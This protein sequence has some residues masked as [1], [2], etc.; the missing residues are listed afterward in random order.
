MKLDDAKDEG[1]YLKQ[2]GE[3]PQAFRLR[4]SNAMNEQTSTL[5]QN[6]EAKQFPMHPLAKPGPQGWDKFAAGQR[7]EVANELA[8]LNNGTTASKA[9]QSGVFERLGA[10]NPGGVRPAKTTAAIA[11]SKYVTAGTVEGKTA[12]KG[13]GGK[14]VITRS[15]PQATSRLG[16]LENR[17]NNPSQSPAFRDNQGHFK[18]PR[19]GMAARQTHIMQTAKK[20]D[21]LMRDLLNPANNNTLPN[22]FDKDDRLNHGYLYNG[23]SLDAGGEMYNTATGAKQYAVGAQKFG[24]NEKIVPT[25][26]GAHVAPSKANETQ[27]RTNLWSEADVDPIRATHMAGNGYVTL[28]NRGTDRL[29]HTAANTTVETPNGQGT[30]SPKTVDSRFHITNDHYKSAVPISPVEQNYKTGKNYPLPYADKTLAAGGVGP[31]RTSLAVQES[32]AKKRAEQARGDDGALR[33][34]ASV[35]YREEA[36]EDAKQASRR[37][38]VEESK[39]VQME[40]MIE[41]QLPNDARQA[42]MTASYNRNAEER[43]R[44]KVAGMV[45]DFLPEQALIDAK[46]AS[47]RREA[48]EEERTQ[49]DLKKF[50]PSDSI[51]AMYGMG[52]AGANKFA[53]S[54]L[55]AQH[56]S[57]QQFL[58]PGATSQNPPPMSDEAKDMYG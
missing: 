56:E 52:K 58:K 51:M 47:A 26:T 45:E 33:M 36:G 38:N 35:G 23:S 25:V 39:R 5:A 18:F 13:G 57:V 28:A 42:A 22:H 10:N 6:D 40:G 43:E 31:K 2:P 9:N 34:A 50:A 12:Y 15:G 21:P 27:S 54:E 30:T 48:L 49:A 53:A 55:Q 44:V 14:K 32:L 7:N 19:E 1:K 29:L 4:M 17:L 11:P 8:A 20:A 37:R 41:D 46:A 3:T 24:N 16:H